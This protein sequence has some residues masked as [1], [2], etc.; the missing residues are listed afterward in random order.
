MLSNFTKD[1]RFD[2]FLINL[3]FVSKNETDTS[4]I[5]NSPNNIFDGEIGTV[6]VKNGSDILYK[7]TTDS[8]FT[9]LS[10]YFPTE[11]NNKVSLL[12]SGINRSATWIK[13]TKS[14]DK[15]WKFLGFVSPY[16]EYCST[17][18]SSSLA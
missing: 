17:C 14:S 4:Y 9:N 8:Q 5:D 10:L 6:L 16:G 7:E 2:K 13:I 15:T 18:S 12:E 1:G 11:I 3:A